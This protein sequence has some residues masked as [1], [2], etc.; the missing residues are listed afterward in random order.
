MFVKRIWSR[1]NPHRRPGEKHAL[2]DSLFSLATLAAAFGV[3]Q[4]LLHAPSQGAN[5]AGP[6]F[7][8]AVSLIARFTQGYVYGVVASFISV[9]CVNTFFTY[10]YSKFDLSIAGYPLTFACM[11][12][13]S[14]LISALTTRLN[15]QDEMR[16]QAETENMRANLLRAV[17]HDLRTPLAS[18]V[19]AS[20]TL[21]ENPALDEKSRRELIAA[22][23]ADARWLTRVTENILSVTKFTG[24]RVVLKKEAE[25]VEEIVADAIVKFR[26]EARSV[27][28]SI[29]RPDGILLALMDATLIEQ[30]LINLFDNAV[31]HGG[32]TTRIGVAIRPAGSF[33]SVTVTDDGQ[34]IDP[35]RL[36]TIFDGSFAASE[37]QSDARR[38]MGIGLSVCRSILLA[39]GGDITACNLPEGGAAFEFKLIAEGGG[40][41]DELAAQQGPDRRG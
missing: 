23:N 30:V 2:V 18:I 9:L 1:F 10:P 13:V 41:E 22:I 14:L 3:C 40:S 39:H 20:S 35:R 32:T 11:L 6:V 8:L 29:D 15:R 25:V 12:I 21:N 24:E 17:S 36:S 37:G 28:V 26:K 16:F 31:E 27:P 7:I 33:V 34:G 5:Y 4:L 19:G 38:N